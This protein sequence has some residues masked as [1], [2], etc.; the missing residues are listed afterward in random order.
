MMTMRLWVCVRENDAQ[1]EQCNPPPSLYLAP[2][3]CNAPPP[4]P[5]AAVGARMWSQLPH[6]SPG[7]RSGSSAG[8]DATVTSIQAY[9]QGQAC[10]SSPLGWPLL[11]AGER[12]Q[13]RTGAR[14]AVRGGRW[15]PSGTRGLSGRDS[16]KD[17]WM[18][19]MTWRIHPLL[20]ILDLRSKDRRKENREKWKEIFSFNF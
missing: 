6:R 5:P 17:T 19:Q 12:G 8:L 13:T 1:A 18:S 16:S 10:L 20:S 9:L 7:H 4:Q 2:W 15:C 3:S 11:G 14:G